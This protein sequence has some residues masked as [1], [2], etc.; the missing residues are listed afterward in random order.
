MTPMFPATTCTRPS[1]SFL[2]SFFSLFSSYYYIDGRGSKKGLLFCEEEGETFFS[3]INKA[4]DPFK[5]HLHAGALFALLASVIFL[6]L[7]PSLGRY[8]LMYNPSDAM[9]CYVNSLRIFSVT[10][11]VESCYKQ[12]IVLPPP[13]SLMAHIEIRTGT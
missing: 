6:L 10:D 3:G 13:P 12:G 9:C 5:S 11:S 2:L 1:S 8:A 7:Q 4:F